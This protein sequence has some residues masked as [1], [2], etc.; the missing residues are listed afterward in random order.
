M[1][2]NNTH[3]SKYQ[4]YDMKYET[5]DRNKNKNKPTNY[6]YNY[7]IVYYNYHSID[8]L[9]ILLNNDNV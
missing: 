1:I 8:Y 2:Q 6:I 3:Q 9:I 4:M 5:K 7:D